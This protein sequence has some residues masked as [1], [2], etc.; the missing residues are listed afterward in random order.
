MTLIQH[1]LTPYLAFFWL[2]KFMTVVKR[3]EQ[4]LLENIIIT[5]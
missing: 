5:Q 1:Q 2:Y 3:K 4:L